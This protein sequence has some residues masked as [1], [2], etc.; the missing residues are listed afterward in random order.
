M[1]PLSKLTIVYEV[2]I[3]ISKKSALFLLW[4]WLALNNDNLLIGALWLI[5]LELLFV[6]AGFRTPE[7]NLVTK[8]VLAFGGYFF[9]GLVGAVWYWLAN[10]YNL[11]FSIVPSLVVWT[12]FELIGDLGNTIATLEEFDKKGTYE[13][14]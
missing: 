14:N 13:A 7:I 12:I 5:S 11:G 10:D 4:M 8:W 6:P 1:K 9:Y 2:Y 3:G